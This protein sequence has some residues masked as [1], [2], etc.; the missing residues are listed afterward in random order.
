MTDFEA[1]LP[2]SEAIS[3]D[4]VLLSREQTLLERMKSQIAGGNIIEADTFG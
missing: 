2:F 4:S 3:D 1:P